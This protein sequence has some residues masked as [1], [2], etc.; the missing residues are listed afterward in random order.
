[1]QDTCL[2]DVLLGKVN[3]TINQNG[4]VKYTGSL[5]PDLKSFD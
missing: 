4:F 5:S 2:S 1:M 3:L